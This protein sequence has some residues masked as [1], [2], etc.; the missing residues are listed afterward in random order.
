L[1]HRKPI[2]K[3][4]QVHSSTYWRSQAV[5]CWVGEMVPMSGTIPLLLDFNSAIEGSLRNGTETLWSSTKFVHGREN[6][7]Q[8]RQ[9]KRLVSLLR[10]KIK[11]SIRES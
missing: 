2:G 4:L 10:S 11:N 9:H 8:P 5:T 6:H 7:L 1:L 3:V